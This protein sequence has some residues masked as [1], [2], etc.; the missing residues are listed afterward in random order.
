MEGLADQL[1]DIFLYNRI[2]ELPV[3]LKGGISFEK[4]KEIF[5]I[6]ASKYNTSIYDLLLGLKGYE[7]NKQMAIYELA[8]Q[9]LLESVVAICNFFHITDINEAMAGLGLLSFQLI[10]YLTNRYGNDHDYTIHATDSMG[11]LETSGQVYP[12]EIEE[13]EIHDY[14][15]DNIEYDETLFITAWLDKKESLS[16]CDLISSRKIKYWL[17]IGDTSPLI[18]NKFREMGYINIF[19]PI[20]QICYLDDFTLR[21]IKCRS[22]TRLYLRDTGVITTMDVLSHIPPTNLVTTPFILDDEIIMHDGM[23]KKILPDWIFVHSKEVIIDIINKIGN[24]DKIV[25]TFITNID[26]FNI[27]YELS[28]N[29]IFPINIQNNE[30]LKEF[31]RLYETLDTDGGMELLQQKGILPYLITNN[32]HAL[33]YLVQDYS[34]VNKQW[35]MQFIS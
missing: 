2:E 30:K 7:A 27:W 6:I 18:S 16:V 21:S 24:L 29:N 20:K 8:T 9:E 32:I 12:E 15:T 23:V 19:L 25:P 14:C 1:Y 5:K 17:L 34:T 31:I 11:W 35:K 28:R 33:K 26:E 22:Y 13:K 3:F 10:D 4:L